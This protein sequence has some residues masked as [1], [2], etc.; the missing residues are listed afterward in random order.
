[1]LKIDYFSNLYNRYFPIFELTC[2]NKNFY[3]KRNTMIRYLN[4]ILFAGMIIM[5]YLANALPLNNKT[6]GQLSDQF[7]NLFVPAGITFSIWGIIYLLLAVYCVLQFSPRSKSIAEEIGWLFALSCVMNGLWI[8]AWHYEKL[9]LSLGIM[10]VL[11]ISLIFINIA[12]KDLPVGFIKA[13]FGIYLGWICIAT[14]ANVTAVLVHYNLSG[15]G[16][17]EEAWTVIMIAAGVFIT[18]LTIVRLNNPFIG[19]SVMWAFTGIIIKQYTDYRIIAMVALA[20]I[21]TTLYFTLNPLIR[22]YFQ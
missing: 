8:I 16:I 7:P 5:N 17:S 21:I 13:V 2:V 14:I 18:S 12:I 6:T 3:T 15:S 22:A 9:P 19:L 10:T 1:M 11:L 20:G 4:I